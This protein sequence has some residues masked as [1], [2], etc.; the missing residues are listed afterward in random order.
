MVAVASQGGASEDVLAAPLL[1]HP[2]FSHFG[3]F[4]GHTTTNLAW[5]MVGLYVVIGLVSL[6]IDRRALMVSSLAYVLYAFS[7]VFK[8]Y[9]IVREELAV[10]A[11]VIGVAL[12]L[13]A[14][15]WQPARAGVMAVLPRKLR[16]QLPPA[17]T[18]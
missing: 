3:V 15:L 11:L 9:G 8:E 2:I 5:F 16:H 10:A 14:A 6:I 17:R 4:S 1:V 18:R 13:L 12:L 7:I